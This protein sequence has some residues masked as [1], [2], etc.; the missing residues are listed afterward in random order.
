MTNPGKT[1]DLTPAEF[2]SEI[3]SV[4]Q[5][6][7]CMAIS[8]EK[9]SDGAICEICEKIGMKKEE[10]NKPPIDDP[11]FKAIAE[12]LMVINRKDYKSI[13]AHYFTQIIIGLESAYSKQD[14]KRAFSWMRYLLQ[15]PNSPESKIIL[16]QMENVAAE[17][18]KPMIF[19][20][21]V[22][23][24]ICAGFSKQRR[25]IIPAFSHRTK[26]ANLEKLAREINE[27]EKKK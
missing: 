25:P 12:R 7:V 22:L 2:A 26:P 23:N 10:L 14:V 6:T 21:A 17:Q 11:A 13:P 20:R 5:N 19:F 3:G 15:Y 16:E 1:S 8:G 9:I 24:R 4:Q 27:T 18:A